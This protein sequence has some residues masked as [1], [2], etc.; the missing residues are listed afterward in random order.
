MADVECRTLYDYL[1]CLFPDEYGNLIRYRGRSDE[2]DV[3]NK[4]RDNVRR[5]RLNDYFNQQRD[6][7]EERYP[8]KRRPFKDSMYAY[9]N[10]EKPRFQDPDDERKYDE[11]HGRFI[12]L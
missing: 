6:N 8:E 5:H 1:N 3:Y 2:L 10:A 11:K 4:Y 7:V 9:G 12:F